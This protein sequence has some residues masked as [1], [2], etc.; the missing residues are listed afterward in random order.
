MVA[1]KANRYLAVAALITLGQDKE[2]TFAVREL[3]PKV[4][5]LMRESGHASV[6]TS[7]S[8][9]GCRSRW[10]TSVTTPKGGS[11]TMSAAGSGRGN[12]APDGRMP[13][14]RDEGGSR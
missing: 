12:R 4:T 9:A 7:A 11:A 3:T 14:A 1:T 2:I 8:T 6:S 13:D 5:A 10:R